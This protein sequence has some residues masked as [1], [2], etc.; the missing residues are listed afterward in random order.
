MNANEI[1]AYLTTRGYSPVWEKDDDHDMAYISA[2]IGGFG[3]RFL[4]SYVACGSVGITSHIPDEQMK[5]VVTLLEKAAQMR[6]PVFLYS[7]KPSQR[8]GRMAGDI[9]SL[10]VY[11]VSELEDY[12]DVQEYDAGTMLVE[13]C[14]D[15]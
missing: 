14:N 5:K 8:T 9:L 7:T 2:L 15:K 13:G 6:K 1:E 12:A 11:T 4:Q 10:G 3:V